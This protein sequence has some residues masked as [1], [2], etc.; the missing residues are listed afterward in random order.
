MEQQAKY[1]TPDISDL[2]VGYECEI[3]NGWNDKWEQK[4]I[5]PALIDTLSK[6]AIPMERWIR[7]KYL[8]V[9]DIESLGWSIEGGGNILDES[10]PKRY[11]QWFRFRNPENTLRFYFHYLEAKPSTIIIR[12]IS[13]HDDCIFEGTCKS[14]NELKLLMKLLNITK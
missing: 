2:H 10:E 4:T 8:D 1:Y 12:K 7:T 6:P 5:T 3:F 14:I 9:Q 13:Y 11:Y